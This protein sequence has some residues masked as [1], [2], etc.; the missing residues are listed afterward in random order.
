MTPWSGRATRKLAPDYRTNHE[1]DGGIRHVPM[2]ARSKSQNLAVFS[3]AMTED[4]WRIVLYYI[5]GVNLWLHMVARS[6]VGY[7]CWMEALA[8]TWRAGLLKATNGTSR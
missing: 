2:P 7:T 3:Q 6:S 5:I 1:L 4:Q 8:W